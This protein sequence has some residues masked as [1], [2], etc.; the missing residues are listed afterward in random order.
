MGIR[1]R[2]GVLN[3]LNYVPNVPMSL[4]TLRACLLALTCFFEKL[5]ALL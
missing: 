3:L 1:S 5:R 2:H 4:R